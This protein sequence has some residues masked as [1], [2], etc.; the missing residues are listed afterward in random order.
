MTA[1]RIIAN[2]VFCFI[3]NLNNVQ[4]QLPPNYL[5]LSADSIS[6]LAKKQNYKHKQTF[7]INDSDFG[8]DY[9][10][11]FDTTGENSNG[12]SMY[13]CIYRFSSKDKN[14]CV[15]CT[16]G[17]FKNSD[18]SHLKELLNNASQYIKDETF[19]TEWGWNSIDDKSYVYLN[20]GEE[21]EEDELRGYYELHY[22]KRLVSDQLAKLPPNYLGLSAEIISHL[23]K[24]Q[25]YKLRDSAYNS[26]NEFEVEYNTDFDWKVRR[27]SVGNSMGSCIYVFSSKD[28]SRCIECHYSFNL[29]R[30]M[31]YFTKQLNND[32]HY[33]KDGTYRTSWGWNSIDGKSYAFIMKETDMALTFDI[34]YRL[35]LPK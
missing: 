26:F 32:P 33:V 23:A 18:L 10:T 7:V 13:I 8:V 22:R 14:N 6:Y 28:K 9:L 11:N 16:Y 30:D 20:R 17:F 24:N 5:G 27:N 19:R 29:I 15:E 1:L 3:L 2:V 21:D 25:N 35:N 31:G 12:N 34:V 4:A